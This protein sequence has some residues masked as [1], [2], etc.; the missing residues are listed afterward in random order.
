MKRPRFGEGKAEFFLKATRPRMARIDA[1]SVVGSCDP[2][3]PNAD[4]L[5][6]Q[7]RNFPRMTRMVA[8]QVVAHPRISA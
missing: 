8:D 4:S 7:C 5:T 3:T 1:D 6:T 2:E